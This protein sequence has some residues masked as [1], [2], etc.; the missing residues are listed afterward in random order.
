MKIQNKKELRRLLEKNKDTIQDFGV[1]KVGVF[2]SFV[3]N[4]QKEESDVDL[5]I[6]F[7]K[8]KKTYRNFINFAQ[9]IEKLLERKVEILTPE[10]LSPYIAP[11]I[12]REVEYVQIGD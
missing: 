3:Q 5:L 8:E 6:E 9:Y 4:K 1:E 2:G 10:S 7:K 12:K 11:H